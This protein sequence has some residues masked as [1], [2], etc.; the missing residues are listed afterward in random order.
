MAYILAGHLLDIADVVEVVDDDCGLSHRNG[1]AGG[2]VEGDR[3]GNAEKR[4]EDGEA[5]DEEVASSSR[6]MGFDAAP[7][8]PVT[9]RSR[10]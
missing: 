3:L 4:E 6:Q 1:D 7:A 5:V 8:P 9:M 10:G 2:V